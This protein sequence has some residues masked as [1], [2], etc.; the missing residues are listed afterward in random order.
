MR[1]RLA[2]VEI[3][4]G[5]LDAAEA[6][7]QIVA[8]DPIAA[9]V[10]WSQAMSLMGRA[11][12]ARRRGQFEVAEQLLAKGWALPRS[13]SQPHMRTLLLVARGYLADQTGD[14]RRALE[15]QADALRAA[16]G[17]GAPRN[18]AYALE[19]CAGALALSDQQDEQ[20]LGAR[21]LG[22]AD[23]IRR[24]TG[25]ALPAG[26]RFDVDRA[27]GRL[28]SA[29]GDDAFAR[30]YALGAAAATNDLVAAVAAL[31]PVA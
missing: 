22:A 6:H 1:A 16:L 31:V 8:D 23:R 20:V 3:L 18:V 9:S 10:P 21:V 29:L 11:A 27:E 14:G 30:E 24:E 12:I 26:E 17:L 28:R 13:K 15:L 7:H 25:G 5:N 2:N 4:R 19:G